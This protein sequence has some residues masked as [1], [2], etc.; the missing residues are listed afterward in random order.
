VGNVFSV[1][2]P[3][4]GATLSLSPPRLGGQADGG[5]GSP[6]SRTH[7]GPRAIQARVTLSMRS[8]SSGSSGLR[9]VCSVEAVFMSPPHRLGRGLRLAFSRAL[10]QALQYRR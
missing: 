2:A 1:K 8:S 7:G 3:V 4:G 6:I 9:S 5:S 10:D